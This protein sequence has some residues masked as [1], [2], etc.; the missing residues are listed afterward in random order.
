MRAGVTRVHKLVTSNE[1][2]ARVLRQ[3]GIEVLETVAIPQI[4]LKQMTGE[5]AKVESAARA[6]AVDDPKRSP[7]LAPVRTTRGGAWLVESEPSVVPQH[8]RTRRL[9]RC[10]THSSAE[11]APERSACGAV[12]PTVSPSRAR[13]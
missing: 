2:K 9:S 1:V 12:V 10:S 7:R 13:A 4:L 6:T 11:P 5:G 3:A 8:G